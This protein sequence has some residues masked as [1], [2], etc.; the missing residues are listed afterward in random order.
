MYQR[1]LVPTDGSACSDEAIKHAVT[2]ASA[3]RSAVVFLFVMN[4]LRTYR[5]GVVT[6]AQA[7]ETLTA[8]GKESLDRAEKVAASVGA[9]AGVELVEGTPAD[10]IVHRTGD[11]DLVVM[12]SH[13]KG[14]WKRLTLGSV[15]QAVLHRTTRPLLV[16]R[17]GHE[18][19]P[20]G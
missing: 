18:G 20:V 9:L 5:E 2:V 8:Q 14:L 15:T 3:M 4:T 13:G 16:V 6:M 7:L 11:F 17:C 12:G 19:Q 10:V 1:I